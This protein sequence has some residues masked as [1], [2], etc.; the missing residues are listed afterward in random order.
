MLE[1]FARIRRI[2]PHFRN[3]L[4]TGPTGSGKELVARALHHFSP[5]ASGPFVVC[6]CS[7]L[8]ET[9]FES[10]L[11]GYVK[12]AFTGAGRDHIG[13]FESADGGTLFLDEI[14]DMP[15]ATQSRLLRV[16]QNQEVRRVGSSS[17]RK[18]N[19]RVIAATNRDL[20]QQIVDRQFR[21]DLY[22][23]LSM[24]EI[25][26]PSL[27]ER[28]EDLP[29]LERHFLEHFSKEYGKPIRSISQRA[30][31]VLRDYLWPGNVRELENALGNACMMADGDT[32]DVRNLPESLR[33]GDSSPAI[34]FG[35]IPIPLHEM[36]R[37]YV[38][39]VL[40]EV[41][42]NKAKAAHVLQISRAKLYRL[43]LGPSSE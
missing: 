11:F 27:A 9:L 24:V 18:V 36:N 6:D 42:G 25:K 17:V 10:E 16:L 41:G 8:V 23:R 4:I 28:K 13:F 39:R 7:A 32:I 37:C 12:G 22:F 15:P 19:V 38:A 43:L 1:I 3:A 40:E 34:E 20:R 14:G 2:G 30:Q 29:L 35:K 5:A 33:L 21:E 26:V 31:A